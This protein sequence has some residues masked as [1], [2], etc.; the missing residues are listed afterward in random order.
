MG[1]GVT[2][3]VLRF[4]RRAPRQRDRVDRD[5]TP[6]G[7]RQDIGCFRFSPAGGG[8]CGGIRAIAYIDIN[9]DF[10]IEGRQERFELIQ[11]VVD[12]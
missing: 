8:G 11:P 9:V 6:A 2:E 3:C 4:Q 10:V 5:V 12:K 1:H 7:I